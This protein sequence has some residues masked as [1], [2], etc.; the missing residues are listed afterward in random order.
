MS[1]GN[2]TLNWWYPI[3]ISSSV[4]IRAIKWIEVNKSLD[5]RLGAASVSKVICYTGIQ[6]FSDTVFMQQV[7]QYLLE[8]V[9]HNWSNYSLPV[10]EQ[11]A[12]FVINW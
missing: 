5:I 3:Y 6:S 2:S 8:Y 4:A 11:R 1:K 9:I 10:M 12:Y 7:S